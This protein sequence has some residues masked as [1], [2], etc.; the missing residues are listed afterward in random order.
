MTSEDLV[1]RLRKRAEIRRQ[2][3]HRRSVQENKPDRLA[4][5]LDEAAG[6]LERLHQRLEDSHY[7][8]NAGNRVA[9]E[10]GSIPDGIECRDTTIDMQDRLID[11]LWYRIE[12]L[13]AQQNLYQVFVRYSD[14]CGNED[15]YLYGTYRAAD[16]SEIE[17]IFPT[18]PGFISWRIHAMELDQMPDQTPKF[19][20][21]QD[22]QRRNR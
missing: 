8:D 16:R 11:R 10:P 13:E 19:P 21:E 5:L 22:I 20:T 18:H 12:E 14:T 6:E 2:I 15:S 4:D 17:S 1:Y 3:P 7:V 9:C